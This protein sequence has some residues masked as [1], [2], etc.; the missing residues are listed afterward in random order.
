LI[1]TGIK[2]LDQFLGGGI[3]NGIITDIF[4]SEGTGKTQLSIQISINALEKGGEVFFQDTTAGFRPERML[5][6]IK[7]RNLEPHLLDKVKVSRITNTSQQIE[8]LFKIQESNRYSLIVI[9]NITDLFSFEYYKQSRFLEKHN[10]FMS[11]MNK[12]SRIAIQSH[13]PIIVTNVIREMDGLHKE[14]LEE[15]I[16]MYTHMKIKL[17]KGEKYFLGEVIPSFIHKR[18]FRYTIT[19]RGII[20]APQAI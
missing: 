4:G 7:S 15:S 1:A 3:K 9:D 14:S 19:E 10:L 2:K 17:L 5:E 12:L 11:Y 13:T 6:L 8:S 20:D 16:N 18:E